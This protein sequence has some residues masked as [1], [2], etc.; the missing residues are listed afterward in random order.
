[1]RL[2]ILLTCLAAVAVADDRTPARTP[3]IRLGLMP[4]APVIDGMLGEDEWKGSALMQGFCS[5]RSAE[6]F[7]APATFR[8]GRDRERLYL[9]APNG[10]LVLFWFT[11]VAF[12]EGEPYRTKYRAECG[13]TPG[14]V[15]VYACFSSDDGK[16]FDVAHEARLFP[17][18]DND[19]GCATTVENA[20]GTFL[21]V[22][23]AHGASGGL[24]SRDEVAGNKVRRL[25]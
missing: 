16:T 10:D 14:R 8:I 17:S 6:L 13:R 24:A 15:G 1:M 21:T 4:K 19:L 3:E 18:G 5:H 11:S 20:D 7:A 25:S 23:Y 9:A 22:F 12:A 2:S